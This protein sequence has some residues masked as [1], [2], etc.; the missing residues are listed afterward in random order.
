M[1]TLKVSAI[2]NAAASVGGLAI[3][4]GGNV[5]GAG[6]DLITSETFSA[7]SAVNVNN[8]FTSTYANYKIVI[9]MITHSAAGD[10]AL[11]MRLRASGADNTT[12]D[13]YWAR[14]AGNTAGASSITGGAAAN[15]W[16]VAFTSASRGNLAS[17]EVFNPQETLRTGFAVGSNID[18]G[19]APYV[20]TY[21]GW[22][23]A[24][25]SFDGFSL[26]TASGNMTGSLRVYGYKN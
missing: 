4:A 13:Y 23:N 22:F 6:L 2:N 1:S 7:V 3:S 9:G 16:Q 18:G 14:V 17:M 10:T 11:N 25:T 19:T 12:S 15:L 26:I 24:T 21:G 8:C 20:S 5:T